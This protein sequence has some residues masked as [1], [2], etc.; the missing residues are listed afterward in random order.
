MAK[1]IIWNGPL[2]DIRRKRFEKGTVEI[3]KSIASNKRAFII[4]GGGETVMFLKK[5]KLD[6]KINFISTGGG[7][8]LDFLAG[9]KLP[10]IKALE[11]SPDKVGDPRWLCHR[12]NKKL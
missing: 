4:V 9:K 6:K 1:T 7:A 8:M 2:G 12:D 11:I 10:G 3:A 5:L